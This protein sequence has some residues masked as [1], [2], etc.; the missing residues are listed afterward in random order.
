M[1]G[2]FS[3]QELLKLNY[4]VMPNRERFALVKYGG[5]IVG[6]SGSI[7]GNT[8]ARNSSGNYVRARTKPVNPNSS[9]Q[10]AARAAIIHIT[11][12]WNET[13]N[14]AQR[15]SWK[16]YAD[17]VAMQNKLGETIFLSGF[18]HFVR[19]NSI[20]LYCGNAAQVNTA[21]VIQTLADTDNTLT[22]A[23]QADQTIDFA[24]NDGADWVSE[25]DAQ[26]MIFCGHPVNPSRSFFA[27]PYRYITRI[28]GNSGTPPTSPLEGLAAPYEFQVG[29]G[30][31]F[32]AR[33]SRADGRLST[34]WYQGPYTFPAV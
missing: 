33:I 6:M 11:E 8:F 20:R 27:G 3:Q 16:E 32:Y 24:Y 25:D 9:R 4:P 19:S 21:P 5:G 18:N 17:A 14:D 12:E 2:A 7:A 34:K 31:W 13:L 15:A 29:H 22:P 28:V 30:V 1:C 10:V 23:P 26:M